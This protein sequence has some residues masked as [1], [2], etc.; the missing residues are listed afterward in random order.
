M[1]DLLGSLVWGVKNGQYCVIEGVGRYIYIYIYIYI[2]NGFRV[3]K[4][5]TSN[6]L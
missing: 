2:Y 6:I 5:V 1:G 4:S 3:A